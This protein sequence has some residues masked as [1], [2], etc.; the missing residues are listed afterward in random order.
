MVDVTDTS[1]KEGDTVTILS[2]KSDILRMAS[3]LDTIP[4]E[5][6]TGFSSRITRVYEFG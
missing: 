4:Y 2:G 6:L 3:K 1:V 5:I